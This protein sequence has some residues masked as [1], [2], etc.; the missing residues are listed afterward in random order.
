MMPSELPIACS[1]T[2][3]ELRGRLADI[4]AV[5]EASLLDVEAQRGWARLRFDPGARDRVAGIVAAEARCCPFLSMELRDEQDALVLTIEA[6]E[7]AETVVEDLVR[8]IRPEV[9][10]GP[11]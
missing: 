2:P 9:S 6:P 3:T 10:S 7:G 11:H 5:G 1:L 8:V 4:A